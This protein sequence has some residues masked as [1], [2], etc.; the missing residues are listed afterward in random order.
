[1]HIVQQPLLTGWRSLAIILAHEG[2]KTANISTKSLRDLQGKG[3][4][5][6]PSPAACCKVD[7]FATR[8]FLFEVYYLTTQPLTPYCYSGGRYCNNALNKRR[9]SGRLFPLPG[10]LRDIGTFLEILL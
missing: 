5:G 9:G 1:M 4:Y 3:A 8:P 10:L 7:S 6:P 2:T